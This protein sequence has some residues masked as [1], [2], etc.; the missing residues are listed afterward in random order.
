M[1]KSPIWRK[2]AY[3]V[4]CPYCGFTESLG[5][6]LNPDEE[7]RTTCKSCRKEFIETWCDTWE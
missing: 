2:W 3:Y 5:D 7:N 4:K 6:D 1:L